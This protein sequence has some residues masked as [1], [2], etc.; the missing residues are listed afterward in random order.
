MLI[1]YEEEIQDKG[2]NSQF[3]A[4]IINKNFKQLLSEKNSYNL[5]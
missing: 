4:Y 1:K 2:Q 5:L 3:Y